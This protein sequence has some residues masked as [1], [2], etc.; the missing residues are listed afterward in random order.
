MI[1]YHLI[2]SLKDIPSN[3]DDV[4]IT[5]IPPN[6]AVS[7]NPLSSSNL[8]FAGSAISVMPVVPIQASQENINQ[9]SQEMPEKPKM[10]EEINTDII[11]NEPNDDINQIQ[12]KEEPVINTDIIQNEP[13]DDTNQ[14]QTKEEPVLLETLEPQKEAEATA[15]PEAPKTGRHPS[16]RIFHR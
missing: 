16:S 12:T 8:R 7:M 10:I 13:N 9:I 2:I 15:E 4:A 14:I 3:P 1:I 6:L 11:P 5:E